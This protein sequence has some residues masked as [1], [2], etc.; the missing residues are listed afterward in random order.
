MKIN[1]N[2]IFFQTLKNCLLSVHKFVYDDQLP[3]LKLSIFNYLNIKLSWKF[4]EIESY[5]HQPSYQ[6]KD[7]FLTKIWDN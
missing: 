6:I 7:H 5:L 2:L 4:T 3:N 1:F